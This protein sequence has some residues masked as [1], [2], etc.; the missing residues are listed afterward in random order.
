MANIVVATVAKSTFFMT[1]SFVSCISIEVAE[2][3]LPLQIRP[4]QGAS[5]EREE[6]RGAC[7]GKDTHRGIKKFPNGN[8]VLVTMV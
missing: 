2:A 5:R 4:A 8:R 7:D 3:F 1:V 6:A